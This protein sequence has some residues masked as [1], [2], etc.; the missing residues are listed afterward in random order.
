MA[1]EYTGYYIYEAAGVNHRLKG[2]RST[3]ALADTAAGLDATLIAFQGT[4]EFPNIIELGWLYDT[5]TNVWREEVVSDMSAQAQ[6]K[7]AANNMLDVFESAIGVIEA[8]RYAWPQHIA[9]W[10]LSGI[11]WQIVNTARVVLNSTRTHDY[12]QKFCEESASWP[13]GTNGDVFDYVDSFDDAGNI[14]EAPTA[15]FS[16]VVEDEAATSIV[17]TML[18]YPVFASTVNLEDAPST[19]KIINREWT[20]DIP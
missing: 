17:T 10:A 18:A 19:K 16:W 15:T 2:I 14:T 8:N 7:D 5:T 4:V 9:D 3:Q 12:R 20:N 11:H 1:G 6:V 13:T